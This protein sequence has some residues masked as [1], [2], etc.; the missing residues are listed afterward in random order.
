M[1]IYIYIYVYFLRKPLS[2]REP[3]ISPFAR[4]NATRNMHT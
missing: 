3:L 1:D 2:S 4:R